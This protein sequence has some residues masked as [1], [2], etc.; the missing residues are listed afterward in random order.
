[1][2]KLFCFDPR[3]NKTVLA[4]EI[5]LDTFFKKVEPKHFM[6]IIQG[7][8]IQENVIEQLKSKGIKNIKIITN[9]SQYASTLDDWLAPDIKVLDYGN[10]K[11]RFMPIH[12][13][14]RE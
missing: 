11:Q 12:R 4:G 1:M 14:K 7:Y 13:M 8:G 3:K 10:G 2:E 9:V 5:E 6:K